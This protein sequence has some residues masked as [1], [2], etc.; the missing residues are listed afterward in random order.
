MKYHKHVLPNGARLILALMPAAHSVGIN[1]FV[2][3]GSRNET[4]ENNGLSHFLEHLAFKG[5]SEFTSSKE[6]S[7]S[8]E[9]LGGILNAYTSDAVTNYHVKVIPEHF[10]KAFSVVSQLVFWPLL[11]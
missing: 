8:I 5:T 3:T 1:V 7:E 4:A 2:G 6:V 10:K 9:G 11:R